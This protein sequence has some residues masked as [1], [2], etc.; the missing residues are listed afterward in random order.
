MPTRRSVL[1][2]GEALTVRVILLDNQPPKSAVMRWRTLG[3]GEWSDVPLRPLGRGV[4]TAV[5]SPAGGTT[6]E[7]HLDVATC[8]GRPPPLARPA[9]R[10]NQTVV[11]VE[12]T[13]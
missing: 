4:H 6:L 13:P 12:N 2:A 10:M 3:R 8:R 5:L 1:S 9:P 11:F 7:Y